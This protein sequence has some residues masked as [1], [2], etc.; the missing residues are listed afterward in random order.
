MS[1]FL[2]P[3]HYWLYE[4]ISLQENLIEKLTAFAAENGNENLGEQLD[5]AYGKWDNRPMEEII[6]E[7]NIHGWL[8]SKVSQVEAK[9]AKGV[10][11]LVKEGGLQLDQLENVFYEEGRKLGENLEKDMPLPQVYKV[12]SDSL[13]DGMPCDHAMQLIK[14]ETDQVVWR[15]N[16][17]VH[18]SYWEAVGGD[19]HHYYALRNAWMKGL[20]EAMNLVFTILEEDTYELRRENIN[21]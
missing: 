19:I 16:V 5:A 21:E 20:T 10:T 7:S 6:D 8:Q 14:Q 15:R 18:Q 4:K 3:I 1:A 12:I 9:L 13:L 17:C 2:G 11:V